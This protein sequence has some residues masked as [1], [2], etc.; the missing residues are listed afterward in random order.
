MINLINVPSSFDDMMND[1]VIADYFNK[2]FFDHLQKVEK[3]S[4]IK[5]TS[6]ATGKA[7]GKAKNFFSKK[8][9]KSATL[10]AYW[11]AD[12]LVAFFLILTSPSMVAISLA[13]I[14]LIMHTYATFSVIAEII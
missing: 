11:G 13:S 1:P 7:T 2:Y 12:T 4:F 6:Y 3:K 10:L 8:E 9:T 14:L 5:R